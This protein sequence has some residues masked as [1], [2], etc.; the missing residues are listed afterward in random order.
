MPAV[1]PPTELLGL[2]FAVDQRPGS[3]R[4]LLARPQHP[5]RKDAIEE[6]LHERRTK[7]ARSSRSL[8]TDAERRFQCLAHNLERM[9]VT[10]GLDAGQPVPRVGSQQPCQVLGIRQRGAVRQSPAQVF[11]E[12]SSRPAGEFARRGQ[13]AVELLLASGQAKPLQARRAARIV[14]TN[15]HEFPRVGHEDL[16]VEF[17]VATHLMALGGEPRVIRG[18]LQLNDTA[19]GKLTFERRAVLRLVCREQPDIGMARTVIG[20]FNHAIDRGL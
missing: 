17:P 8:E 10:G 11:S 18:G 7:Q 2:A 9:A 20:N 16:P 12:N 19:F 15:E 5:R 14:G 3:P 4:H 1:L 13:Q 6:H